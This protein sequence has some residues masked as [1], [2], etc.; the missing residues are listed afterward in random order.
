MRTSLLPNLCTKNLLEGSKLLETGSI[1]EILVY[2]YSAPSIISSA[3]KCRRTSWQHPIFFAT[4]HCRVYLPC[5]ALYC[6]VLSLLYCTVVL[7]P[8]AFCFPRTFILCC[9]Y[10]TDY[11]TGYMKNTLFCTF[12]P[13]KVPLAR[14]PLSWPKVQLLPWLVA[15]A[16]LCFTAVMYSGR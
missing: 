8:A 3:S 9:C 4:A 5:T 7:F 2:L 16:P 13:T 6:P 12:F 1:V 14:Q 15:K 10:S 11:T